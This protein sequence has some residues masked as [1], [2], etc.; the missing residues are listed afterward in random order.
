MKT[1]VI[2]LWTSW[3]LIIVLIIHNR[4]VTH[5]NEELNCTMSNLLYYINITLLSSPLLYFQLYFPLSFFFF[6]HLHFFA[7][8]LSPS[9]FLSFHLH[10]FRTFFPSFPHF[11]HSIS[12]FPALV[13]LFSL[14]IF[15]FSSPILSLYFPFLFPPSFSSL[16]QPF[17]FLRL[18]FSLSLSTFLPFPLSYFSLLHLHPSLSPSTLFSLSICSFLFLIPSFLPVLHH[19]SHQQATE[20]SSAQTACPTA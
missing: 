7:L 11:L 4:T 19:R 12:R 13:P 16:F 6:P 10:F 2:L 8:L 9:I 18:L 3:P 15:L 5:V 17:P 1:I 14:S 20:F